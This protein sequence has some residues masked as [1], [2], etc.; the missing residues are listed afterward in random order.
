MQKVMLTRKLKANLC[1]PEK[2]K[3]RTLIIQQHHLM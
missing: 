1:G 2:T 3:G